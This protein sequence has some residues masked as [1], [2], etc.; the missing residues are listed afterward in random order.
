[1]SGF[2][3]TLGYLLVSSDKAVLL[4]DF[5]YLEQAEK[6]TPHMEVFPLRK[7]LSEAVA[8][9]CQREG[10]NK[11]GFEEEH[12]TYYIYKILSDSIGATLIPLRQQVEQLRAVKEPLEIELIKE[13]ARLTDEAFEEIRPLVKPGIVEKDV[14][15][16]L[17]Y[18]LHKN[19]GEGPSFNYI[20]AS[21]PRSALPHGVASAKELQEG[22]LVTID[23]GVYYRG[24]VSDMTR[25]FFL[26]RAEKEHREL[27]EV[28][29]KAQLKALDY[30]K[31]GVTG[32]EVDALAREV[33]EE[34]GYGDKFGH[35]LG[36]GVG[37]EPHES[38]TLSQR[39]KDKLLSGMV[40][41]VEPGVYI[42]EWGGIR[43]EDMV[44]IRKESAEVLTHSPRNLI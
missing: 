21:G 14:A 28:L 20:V 22:E 7:K 17:Q 25:T 31:E 23:F 33:I 39:G 11:V 26:G 12:L 43:I 6:Q 1:M 29:R 2:D 41:T 5:R 24:Y 35:G 34:A 18:I 30:I 15:M 37:L 27:W 3:G 32:A 19:G 16:E 38:P 42:P 40:V 13:A 4:T 8:Y 9:L 44:L 10:W 36:H